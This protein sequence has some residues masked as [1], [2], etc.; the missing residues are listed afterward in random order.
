FIPVHFNEMVAAAQGADAFDRPVQVHVIFAVKLTQ[1]DVGRISMG[2]FADIKTGGNV[3]IN[4]PVQ[5]FEVNGL[6][7]QL[8]GFHA[9]ANV[10]PHQVRHHLIGD[11][12]GGAD[13]AA[14]AGVNVGHDPDTAAPGKFL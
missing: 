9:A 8:D 1:V 3:I 6:F 4:H 12:H 2:L 11:G 5:L 7:P 10:H 13:G 14:D